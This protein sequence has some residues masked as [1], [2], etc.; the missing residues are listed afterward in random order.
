MNSLGI[1]GV[2]DRALGGVRPASAQANAAILNMPVNAIESE[3]IKEVIDGSCEIL[4]SMNR[5]Y[6]SGTLRFCPV[7][8]FL[9]VITASILLLKALSLGTRVTELQASLAV[10]ETSISVFKTGTLDDMHIALRYGSLLEAYVIRFR[11]GMAPCTNPRDLSSF[12][13]FVEWNDGEV[14]A[15][16]GTTTNDLCFP[17]GDWLSLPLDRSLAPFGLWG[18]SSDILDPEDRAWDML[19]SLPSVP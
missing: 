7:R 14:G 1:Q 5:F 15:L 3:F 18:S 4:T 12:P 6:E 9:R 2:I 11:Q 13:S 19:W 17:S 10:L 16:S 8:I